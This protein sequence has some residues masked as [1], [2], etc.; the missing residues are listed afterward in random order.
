MT[1]NKQKKLINWEDFER[2][3]FGVAACIKCEQKIACQHLD[4]EKA[5]P[6]CPLWAGLE[7]AK[8]CHMPDAKDCH[9]PD[10]TWDK[11]K[12]KKW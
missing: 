10:I 9:M 1:D 4:I 7:D 3:M 8:D 2:L 11:V 12:N 6:T 5:L